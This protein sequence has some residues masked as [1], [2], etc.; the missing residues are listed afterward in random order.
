MRD[1]PIFC[2]FQFKCMLSDT[3]ALTEVIAL[4][5]TRLQILRYS[6]YWYFFRKL[7]GVVSVYFL[8]TLQKYFTSL[9]PH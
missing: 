7:V 1:C 8:K 2:G 3:A 4:P 5:G 9:N 6:V